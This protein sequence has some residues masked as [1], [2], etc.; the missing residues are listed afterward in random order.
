MLRVNEPNNRT[1]PWALADVRI[2]LLMQ[3][4]EDITY[5]LLLSER[6]RI[7]I[8]GIRVKLPE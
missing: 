1:K 5:S 6:N 3:L 4:F 8:A 7:R 2:G